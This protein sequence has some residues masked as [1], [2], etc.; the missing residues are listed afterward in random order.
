MYEFRK[1]VTYYVTVPSEDWPEWRFSGGEWENLMGM[2][3][4]MMEPPEGLDEALK[5]WREA[6]VWDDYDD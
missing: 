5:A 4:E 3:W 2:S 1:G 6:E